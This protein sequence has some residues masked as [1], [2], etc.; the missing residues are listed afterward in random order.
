MPNQFQDD[1]VANAKAALAHANTKFPTTHASLQYGA[2]HAVGTS[3][4][5]SHGN[6]SAGGTLTGE[7]QSANAGIKDKMDNVAAYTAANPQ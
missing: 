6:D 2:G 4:A 5:A 3:F 1:A 7:A